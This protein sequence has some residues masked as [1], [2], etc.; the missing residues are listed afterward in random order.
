MKAEFPTSVSLAAFADFCGG[1]LHGAAPSDVRISGLCTDSGEADQNTVFVAL[2]GTRVDGHDYIHAAIRNGCRC[3]LCE[4]LPTMVTESL[5]CIVVP[6]SELALSV[7]AHAYQKTLSCQKIAVT[8]S[9]GKTTTKDMIAAVLSESRRVYFSKGN[10]NSVIGMPL[11]ILEIDGACEF[12]VLE[13]GM[14]AFGEIKRM[15]LTAEPNIGVITNIGSSHLE[16]LGSRENICR[17]KT[18]L[19][20][21]LKRDGLLLLNGD[22]PLLSGIGDGFR[23]CYVSLC[24]SDADYFAQNIHVEKD[25]TV[26][27]LSERGT[28]YSDMRIRVLGRHN[29]YAALYA[30]AVGR[31]AGL[32]TDEIRHGL[33]RYETVGMRQNRYPFHGMT[34]FED[35]YNASPESMCA[36]LETVAEFAGHCGGR[37]VAVLGDMLELGTESDSMHRMVGKKLAEAGFDWLYTVGTGGAWIAQGATYGG[38]DRSRILSVTDDTE[39]P[40]LCARLLSDLQEGD[41]ILFKA[42]RSIRLERLIDLMKTGFLSR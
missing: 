40:T 29:V 31:E 35:C 20:L 28:C 30:F 9:V 8:G 36:A 26:F 11:S 39:F 5:T 25:C 6:D 2:R 10:H 1:V 23:T 42:S 24:H 38:M 21:G 16:Q 18:E 3:V 15:S 33:L 14:S 7:C 34:I 19:L 4:R 37:S 32:S 17:A 22:E 13:M 12:A 41:S 27:D